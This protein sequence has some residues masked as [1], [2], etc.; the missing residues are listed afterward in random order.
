MHV[1]L[2]L[3]DP[4]KIRPGILPVVLDGCVFASFDR[5]WEEGEIPF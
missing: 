2:S 4:A 1:R 3:I 5:E